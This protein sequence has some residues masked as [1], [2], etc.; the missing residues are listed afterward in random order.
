M[1]GSE[2]DPELAKHVLKAAPKSARVVFEN[3]RIRVIEITMKRGQ[4][5]PMHSHGKGLSYSLN[6]GRIRSTGMDGRS[7]AFR[8]KRGEISW[9]DRDGTET[10]SVENLGGLLRELSVEFKD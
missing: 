5:I 7:K 10:H 8:V 9:S 2:K 4:T 3:D 1:P 6:G